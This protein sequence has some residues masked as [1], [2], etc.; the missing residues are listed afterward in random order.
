MGDGSICSRKKTTEHGLKFTCRCTD[1]I[2]VFDN[3]KAD[4][5]ILNAAI[6]IKEE[7]PKAKVVLVTKDIALRLKA[8]PLNVLAEDYETG[9]LELYHL[10]NDRSGSHFLVRQ[11]QQEYVLRKQNP[12]VPELPGVRI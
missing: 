9:N 7:Y 1:A 12:R 6:V 3:S 11:G 8:K 5:R 10:A 4:H 2:H